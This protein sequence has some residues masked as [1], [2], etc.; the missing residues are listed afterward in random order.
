MTSQLRTLEEYDKDINSPLLIFEQLIT[1]IIPKEHWYSRSGYAG[2]IETKYET[3][4]DKKFICDIMDRFENYFVEQQPEQDDR[5]K[6]K[7]IKY[8]KE[9]L[10]TIIIDKTIQKLLETAKLNK[11]KGYIVFKRT[12]KF[13]IAPEEIL[14]HRVR[15]TNFDENRN[16]LQ[17]NNL[18][19]VKDKSVDLD[20]P[21]LISKLRPSKMIPSCDNIQLQEPVKE[22]TGGKRKSKKSSKS[23]KVKKTRK[24][25]PKKT[26]RKKKN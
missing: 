18:H 1:L 20:E 2:E 25:K 22:P 15:L 16:I 24:R 4:K 26:T 21:S 13:K 17:K 19:S 8:I 5:V 9:Q 14:V 23:K 10:N 3:F 7:F 6:D 12:K 11:N